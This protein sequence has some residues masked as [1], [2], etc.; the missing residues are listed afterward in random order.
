MGLFGTCL[1]LSGCAAYQIGTR[2]L[3]PANVGTVHVPIFESNSFRRGLGER[4]T[5]AV[6][7]EIERRTPYKVIGNSYEADSVLSG[8]ILH[9]S[10]K[11]LIETRTDEPRELE[12]NF[13]VEVRWLNRRGQEIRQSQEIPLQPELVDIN[14]TTLIVPEAGQSVATAQQRAIDDLAAQI[15]GMME[16]PW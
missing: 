1:V 8:L 11:V 12:L 10:K 15:V 16:A 3:F 5:E 7:K 14:Q 13:V 6:V 9:D 4:L 2:S